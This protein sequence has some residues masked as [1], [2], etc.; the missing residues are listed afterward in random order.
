MLRIYPSINM[1][2]KFFTITILILLLTFSLNVNAYI[3]PGT[4]SY[5]I[6]V[7]LAAIL[8][9]V[10]TMKVFWKRIGMILKRIVSRGK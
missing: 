6:Q 5:V 7:I 3:D 2:T 9:G 10:V 8:G 4:G 1:K